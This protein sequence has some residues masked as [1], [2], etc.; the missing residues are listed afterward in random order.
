ML[1]GNEGLQP[2]KLKPDFVG[3]PGLTTAKGCNPVSLAKV[4]VP[5]LLSNVAVTLIGEK[6]KTFSDIVLKLIVLLL[7]F[8]IVIFPISY[9][10]LRT[11]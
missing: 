7:L 11:P 5:P 6:F 10:F 2:V 1:L 4:G 8:V 3:E 9:P